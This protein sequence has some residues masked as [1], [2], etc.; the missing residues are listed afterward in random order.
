M[1]WVWLPTV[2]VDIMARHADLSG[3]GDFSQRFQIAGLGG[4]VSVVGREAVIVQLT[5]GF[6]V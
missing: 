5:E 6:M 2:C 4:E 1:V 3:N